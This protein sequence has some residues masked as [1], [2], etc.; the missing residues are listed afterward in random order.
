MFSS[1][2]GFPVT[3][4]YYTKNRTLFKENS[5]SKNSFISILEKFENN[6]RYKNEAKLKNKYYLNGKEIRDNQLLEELINQNDPNCLSKL[7]KAEFLLELEEIHF[8]GDSQYQ[9][10]RK[11]LQPKANPFGLYIYSP[12]EGTLSLKIYPDKTISLFELNKFNEGSAYC[13]SYNDLFISGG[14]DNNNKDFW[15]INNN[16]FEVKKKNML[17]NKRNHSMIFL[18]C[19]EKEEWI[20]II[21]GDDK[22]SFYYDLNKNY[23]INWGD[24]NDIHIRPALMQIGEYLYI[25]D[26]I[27]LRKNY[28]ERTKI[29]TPNRKW[30]KNVLNI[31]NKIINYF[32]SKYGVSFD[33]NGKILLLGGDNNNKVKN[34]Y[35][36][37]PSNNSI[38]LS[39]NGKNDKMLFDDK[40]FYKINK[41]YNIG[42][43]HNLNETKEIGVVDK[44][45][46]SLIKIYI[47]LPSENNK[48]K[49]ICNLSF[50][51]N[52]ENKY[53]NEIGNLSIKTTNI[54]NNESDLIES[55]YNKVN[56]NNTYDQKNIKINYNQPQ[57]LAYNNANKNTLI[58]QYHHNSFQKNNN[59]Q[60]YNNISKAQYKKNNYS[61]YNEN[62]NPTKDNPKVIIIQDEYSPIS[63]KTYNLNNVYKQSYNKQ[64]KTNKTKNIPYK[65]KVYNQNY[66]RANDKAKVE[67]MF[68]VYTPIKIDYE[69]NKPGTIKKYAY[70]YKKKEIYE[71]K[72]NK[73]E[74]K[75]SNEYNVI[76]DKNRNI[77]KNID[78]DVVEYKNYEKNEQENKDDDLFVNEEQNKNQNEIIIEENNNNYESNFNEEIEVQQ[79]QN[80]EHQEQ[81][82]IERE[83]ENENE[84][85]ENNEKIVNREE[86]ME[87]EEREEDN[88]YI[89]NGEENEE[90]GEIEDN[91]DYGKEEVIE[92]DNN[93]ISQNKE[94]FNG[95]LPKDSLE[96]NNGEKLHEEK[97]ELQP[98][99][100]MNFNNQNNINDNFEENNN[101][102]N[103]QENN[104]N[105][106]K[107]GE[108]FHSMSENEENI[109]EEHIENENFQEMYENGNEIKFEGENENIE[110]N[111]EENEVNNINDEEENK[112]VEFNQEEGGEGEEGEEGVEGQEMHIEEEIEVNGE[113]GE[114]EING[115]EVG[116]E[117]IYND[118]QEGEGEIN[119]EE[120]GGEGIYND[121]EE[122]NEEINGEEEGG[123]GIYNDGE[124]EMNYEEQEGNSSEIQNN[125]ENEEQEYE[126]NNINNGEENNEES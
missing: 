80:E 84:K 41:R 4:V 20:F 18:N 64:I 63:S 70:T 122:G 32:P 54:K 50:N 93:L 67:I 85:L 98:Q 59:N 27:N 43:S 68:D 101:E 104:N 103:I 111:G 100:E 91:I 19:N 45:T 109:N 117:G 74:E 56:N 115:E 78:N 69:L 88:A 120:E 13:N 2:K 105:I 38:I 37:E 61:Q 126:E 15:I 3:I 90:K 82:I 113:E 49:A 121:G 87:M 55:K 26:S 94:I 125:A 58:S 99:N 11:I 119:G 6:Y 35:I 39:Q 108:E 83:E 62:I 40:T 124:E 71:E 12:K 16:N 110:Y 25:F 31:D 97:N 107:D 23:F 22:K 33:S 96:F 10:Y 17:M 60:F 14:T 86:F 9:N 76:S 89:E 28:F 65:T 95:E 34:T 79:D 57:S 52:I 30:E 123:E 21:G 118:D 7:D 1:N 106:I 102:I 47:S 92:K 75:I 53:N 5:N 51:D 46:Q 114:G 42:L 73:K 36:Y 8:T 81:N 44:E 77:N 72:Y 112:I 24:T 48:V 66:N 116:G 29:I